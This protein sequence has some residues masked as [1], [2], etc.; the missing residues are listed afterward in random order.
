MPNDSGPTCESC[1]PPCQY[2]SVFDRVFVSYLIAGG[3]LVQWTLLNTFFDPLPYEFTLQFGRTSS[4]ES[5]DWEDVG[6]PVQNAFFAMD[7]EQR[8]YGKTNWA[9]YRVK[10]ITP[11]SASPTIH[12]ARTIA[13][14]EFMCGPRGERLVDFLGTLDPQITTVGSICY[15][16]YPTSDPCYFRDRLL[17][18]RK[19]GLAARALR[20]HYRGIAWADHEGRN[21]FQSGDYLYV[22]YGCGKREAQLLPELSITPSPQEGRSQ[23]VSQLPG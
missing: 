4:N 21:V 1:D 10:L 18:V 19:P 15:D 23:Q 13:A 14:D 8:L 5:N 7:M 20:C 12:A 6:M 11:M 3:T 2:G 17:L 9:F 16:L 22:R